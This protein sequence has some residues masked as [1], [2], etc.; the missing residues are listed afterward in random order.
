[1]NPLGPADLRTG[2]QTIY[3][4][5][6]LSGQPRQQLVPTADTYDQVEPYSVS[7]Q[8]QLS[9]SLKQGV[10]AS[11]IEPTTLNSP[12]YSLDDIIT[13]VRTIPQ[14]DDSNPRML[15]S[16][17]E[18]TLETWKRLTGEVGASSNGTPVEQLIRQIYPQLQELL[19]I[20]TQ[21]GNATADWNRPF[22]RLGQY[23]SLSPISQNLM[24]LIYGNVIEFVK[25][26]EGTGSPLEDYIISYDTYMD[27]ESLV[28]AIGSRVGIY[29][30]LDGEY[31]ARELFVDK[32]VSVIQN[33][34]L[35]APDDQTSPLGTGNGVSYTLKDLIDIN[36]PEFKQWLIKQGMDESVLTKNVFEQL[37]QDR[38]LTYVYV[39]QSSIGH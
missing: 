26:P 9:E 10:T 8:Y 12:G 4:P 3:Y 39:K 1:M 6:F 13:D 17:K 22:Q 36:R 35:Y 38:L 16:N 5:S 2:A 18:L 30:P 32:I 24:N 21:G 20:N 23:I 37:Y 15:T 25:R 31:W 28:R 7:N 19:Y 33:I 14:S 34:N 27:N 11:F 29:L